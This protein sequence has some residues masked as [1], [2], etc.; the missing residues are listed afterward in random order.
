MLWKTLRICTTIVALCLIVLVAGRTFMAWV[1][2]QTM[3]SKAESAGF[4]F[5]E[6]GA[7]AGINGVTVCGRTAKSA[8]VEANGSGVCWLDY[9]NDGLLDRWGTGCAAAFN[10]D[11]LVDLPVTTIGDNFI[12]RNNGDGAFTDIAQKAGVA[13]GFDWHTGA[14][15]SDY[16]RLSRAAADARPAKQSFMERH[17]SLV[18]P[19][20][21]EGAMDRLG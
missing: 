9:N 17:A 14:A 12:Y 10:N 16:R 1:S 6:V 19:K 20:G 5:R 8:V 21:L 18:G 2:T 3:R 4:Q 13:G 7:K 11:G 15:F